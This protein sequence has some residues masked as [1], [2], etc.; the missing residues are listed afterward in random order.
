MCVFSPPIC[1]MMRNPLSKMV[2]KRLSNM[3]FGLWFSFTRHRTSVRENVR[4]DVSWRDCRCS[5]TNRY[6]LLLSS[7]PGSVADKL[8]FKNETLPSAWRGFFGRALEFF[9]P[10]FH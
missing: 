8:T 5:I 10:D 6:W 2:T 3:Q 9:R 7:A 1:G 4:S